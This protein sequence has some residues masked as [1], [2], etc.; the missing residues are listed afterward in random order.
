MVDSYFSNMG[1]N[2]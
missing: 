2:F 1:E